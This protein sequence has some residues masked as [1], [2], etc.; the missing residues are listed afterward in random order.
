MMKEVYEKPQL[1][2][3]YFQDADVI[4]ASGVTEGSGEGDDMD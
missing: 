2:E 4:I 3:I 1:E